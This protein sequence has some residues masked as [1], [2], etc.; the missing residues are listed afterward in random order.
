MLGDSIRR[1]RP[2]GRKQAEPSSGGERPGRSR[3]ARPEDGLLWA[4]WLA[5]VLLVAVGGFAVGYLLATQVF[6]PRPE[7]AG[8]GVD[9]PALY[10]LD[11]AA[12]ERALRERGLEVGEVVTLASARSRAGR[13]LAQTPVPDQQLR[14][15]AA[16]A[17]VVS[18]GPSQV[19]VP[20]VAGLAPATARGLLEAAGFEVAVQEVRAAGGR[21]VV[22]RTEPAA[23]ERVRLP[24]SL[25]MV[26]NLGPEM[27]EPVEPVDSPGAVPGWPEWR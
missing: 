8:A 12:A 22:M 17:L 9:V 6:F 14:P 13:V 20:P 24:A 21:D 5:A 27:V 16:V 3:T 7:T 26:V 25:T 19:R 15:G 11:R 4:R 2:P 23:G 18:D 10:G 1:R